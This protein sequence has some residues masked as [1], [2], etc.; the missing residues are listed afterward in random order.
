[1]KEAIPPHLV[2]EHPDPPALPTPLIRRLSHCL[3]GGWSRIVRYATST[4][5]FDNPLDRED[6][7]LPPCHARLHPLP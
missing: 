1:V 3:S 4:V 6:D 5:A 7:I 2:G